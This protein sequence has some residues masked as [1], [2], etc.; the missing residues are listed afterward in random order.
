MM[1][2]RDKAPRNSGGESARDR[3]LAVT[4]Q[5]VAEYG[6]EGATTRKI[7][8]EADAN[9]AAIHYHFGSKD[10]LLRELLRLRWSQIEELLLEQ[11]RS[12][13]VENATAT[14]VAMAIVMPS[15]QLLAQSPW[16]LAFL[17]QIHRHPKYPEW[18]IEIYRTI[19]DHRII[20][21]AEVAAPHLDPAERIIWV[22]WC[23]RLVGSVLGDVAANER[24]VSNFLKKEFPLVAYDKVDI[25]ALL[26]T[27][28]TRI[29][30]PEL[31][32]ITSVSRTLE[33]ATKSRRE[34]KSGAPGSGR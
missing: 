31:Q 16:A 21:I 1:Q 2:S 18:W 29:F 28:I 32:Q 15:V 27:F 11:L 7:L 22:M 20:R 23:A 12:T 17:E 30:S 19:C 14:D 34:P 6:V 8:G 3:I 4:E 33:L 9:I 13:S 26:V 10:D 25:P 24:L 5:L